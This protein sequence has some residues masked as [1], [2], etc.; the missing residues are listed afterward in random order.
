MDYS[1]LSDSALEALSKGDHPDYTKLSDQELQALSAEHSPAPETGGAMQT[2]KDLGRGSLQGATFGFSDEGLGALGATKDVLTGDAGLQDWTTKYRQRQ[3][4][5]QAANEDAAKRSPIAYNVG[6][7]G[8]S[9]LAGL[10]SGG[11]GTAVRAG[12]VAA[13]LGARELAALAAKGAAIGATQG[14][15]RSTGTIEDAPGKLASDTFQG[16][17]AG[18]VLAPILGIAGNKLANRAAAKAEA[19]A[20]QAAGTA[21]EDSPM[22]AQVAEAYNAGKAGESFNPS[23]SSISREAANEDAAIQGL[24]GKFDT[25]EEALTG[26]K[27]EVL[28]QSKAI[29]KPP[30]SS[31]PAAEGFLS[32]SIITPEADKV[33][34]IPSF[35]DFAK[36]SGEISRKD[37]SDIS[38][39]LDLY[40]NGGLS[41]KEADVLRKKIQDV[42][43]G[44]RNPDVQGSLNNA[45]D[46]LGSAIEKNVPGYGEANKNIHEF[47]K[48]GKETLLSKGN[49]ADISGIKVSNLPNEDLKTTQG[50]QKIV[51]SLRNFKEGAT[52]QSQGALDKTIANLKELQQSNPDLFDTLGINIPQLEGQFYKAADRSAVA[53]KLLP[54]QYLG[55]ELKSGKG[56]FG[57]PVLGEQGVLRGAN[58]AGQVSKK[59]SDFYKLSKEG[60][61]G[62]AQ[63]LIHTGVESLK[64][65]GTGLQQSIDSG[66]QGKMNAAMF[67]I[68]QNPDARKALGYSV[69]KQADATSG[70]E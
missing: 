56:L 9:I 5:E 19:K 37:L 49:D 26:T 42:A 29:I 27:N 17:V 38:S 21:I 10:L 16:G 54:G 30:Q 51:G 12:G 60:V 40:S 23:R 41:A 52:Q 36:K 34:Q 69:E 65:L 11:T 43:Q 6:D 8:T 25:A 58:L 4:A 67:T 61:A 66:N 35:L 64:S 15:G 13:K 28:G 59:A 55:N 14:F 1:K 50:I 47:L 22:K 18:G 32:N 46:E 31:T 20:A 45:A 70:E 53:Q 2:A 3:Q 57:I 68:L 63:Q 39:G 33:S 44:V 24:K 62:A 7:Y 48:A